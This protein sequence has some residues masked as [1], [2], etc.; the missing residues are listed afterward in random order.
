M[1]EDASEKLLDDV[2]RSMTEQLNAE[3]AS[4]AQ[5]EAQ[6]GQVWDTVEMSADF[7]VEGFLAPFVVVRRKSD[8]QRGSLLFAHS[9]RLY[10]QFHESSL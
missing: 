9:P 10:F 1:S 6:Y 8:G 5:L 7:E 4:R 2:R 3:K